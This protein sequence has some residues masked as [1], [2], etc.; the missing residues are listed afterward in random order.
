MFR[1]APADTSDKP[2]FWPPGEEK[3]ARVRIAEDL[4]HGRTRT[5]P[6]KARH[7]PQPS[8]SS[9]GRHAVVMRDFCAPSKALLAAPRAGF[10]LLRPP[11]SPTHFH[12]DPIYIRTENER[13]LGSGYVGNICP[14]KR[15]IQG[16]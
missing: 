14:G 5:E 9:R 10:R 16:P 2:F 7:I 1:A 15:L 11:F 4:L 8:R 3:D 6:G 13:K 12:E